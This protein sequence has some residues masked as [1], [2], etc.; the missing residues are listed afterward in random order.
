MHLYFTKNSDISEAALPPPY[1]IYYLL[2]TDKLKLMFPKPACI[3]ES[4][5]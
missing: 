5:R 3:S 1:P 4:R 2:Y